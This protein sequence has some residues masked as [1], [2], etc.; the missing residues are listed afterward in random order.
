MS[1][2]H[3]RKKD[4]RNI[5]TEKIIKD[6]VLEL[7][8]TKPINKITV[9]EVCKIADIN[10]GTFYLHYMDC[11]HVLEQ[12]Q[13]EFC[14]K[15]IDSLEKHK[16]RDRVDIIVELHKLI[17]EN[18]DIYL[19][20][21]RAEQPLHAFKKFIDYGKKIIIEQLLECTTLTEEEA[22]WIAYYVISGS[23]AVSQRYAHEQDDNLHREHIFNKFLESGFSG[24]MCEDKTKK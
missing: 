22:E 9:A 17:R 4:R 15:L 1:I 20:F 13:D 10:R 6:T 16:S 18:N 2:I 7:L 24:F 14:D 11:Y 3:M 8:Q 23:F 12:I 21:M 19:I 5:Y